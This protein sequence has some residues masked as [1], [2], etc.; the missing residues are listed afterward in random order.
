MEEFLLLLLIITNITF[1][2]NR[3]SISDPDLRAMG[4]FRI[5]PLLRDNAWSTQ[6][7]LPKKD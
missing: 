2:Y 7:T 4:R 5:Q 1:Y 3:F 6:Y